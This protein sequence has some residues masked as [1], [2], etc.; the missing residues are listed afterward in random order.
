MSIVRC[1]VQNL[2]KLC[3]HN[4]S[5]VET[6][7]GLKTCHLLQSAS[8]YF[9]YHNLFSTVHVESISHVYFPSTQC[10]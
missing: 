9:S 6:Y 1:I 4:D 3:D 10:A 5:I 8:Y 2:Y 7:Y